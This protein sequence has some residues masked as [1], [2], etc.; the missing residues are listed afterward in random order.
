MNWKFWQRR[1][2]TIGPDPTQAHSL[3]EGFDTKPSGG[4]VFTNQTLFRGFFGIAGLYLI[5]AVCIGIWWSQE[6]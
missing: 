2:D 3:G 5:G 4:S 6:P 1:D